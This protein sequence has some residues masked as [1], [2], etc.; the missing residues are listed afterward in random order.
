MPEHLRALVVILVVAAL[1]FQIAR[2]LALRFVSAN[3]FSSWRNAW[4]GLTLCLFVFHNFWVYALLLVVWARHLA[5]RESQV[6]GVFFFLLFI[7]PPATMN[8]PGFGVINHLFP[9]SQYR[10]LTLALLLPAALGL[11]RRRTTIRYGES[12]VDWMV[13]GYLALT[14]ALSFR[15]ASLTGGLRLVFIHITDIFLPYYVL[16]RSLR[17]LEDFKRAL[18]GFALGVV[19]LSPL[20]LFEV[21]RYWKLY[22]ALF[23]ALGFNPFEYGGY[24]ERAGVLRPDVTL[25]NSIVLGYVLMVGVGCYLFLRAYMPS[26]MRTHLGMGLLVGGVIWSLS[27]GPWM[28]L[29]LLILVYVFTGTKVVSRT[30]KLALTAGMGLLIAI[31]FP[32]GQFL[33][34]LLPFM[35]ESEAG[36]VEYRGDLLTQAIPVVLRNFWFGST[37]F[38]SAPEMQVMI[39]GQGII[40]IVNSYLAVALSYGMVALV[41]YAGA[42]L[43]AALHTW[44]SLRQTKRHDEQVALL[45]RALLATLLSIMLVIYTV[46]GISAVPLVYWS[47]IGICVA[48]SHMVRSSRAE[49]NT[50]GRPS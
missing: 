30:I 13:L 1:V 31:Q 16:S 44:Q 11:Y 6:V 9:V 24:L 28:G 37:D 25:G 41:F 43:L 40:D 7:A 5:K 45:G 15:D 21:L 35:G 38:L 22:T 32:V 49:K 17:S 34:D 29:G 46:S 42:F 20:A 48:Y 19:V 27:R 47:V 8:I 39:Q 18:F 3:T 50:L 2:P 12:P 33:I 26:S 14:C 4:L 23:A 36:S 10:L